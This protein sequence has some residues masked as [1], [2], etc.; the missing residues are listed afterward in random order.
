M[1]KQVVHLEAA[2]HDSVQALLPWYVIQRLDRA[3]LNMVQTHLAACPQCRSDVAWEQKLRP[4]YVEESEAPGDVEASLAMLRPRLDRQRAG[5]LAR[6]WQQLRPRLPQEG[7]WMRWTVAAQ[8]AVIVLLS[9]LVVLPPTTTEPY[10]TL[11]SGGR[12]V[13]GNAMVVFTPEATEQDIRAALR[14]SGARLVDG[15]TLLGAYVLNISDPD[16]L[17]R[18]RERPIVVRAES[19]EPGARP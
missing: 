16:A 2:V 7:P 19:L 12:A 1:K 14:L 13:A 17:E 15:P 11:G 10:R 6:L 9:V 5:R 18:L 3:E 4:A 8:F